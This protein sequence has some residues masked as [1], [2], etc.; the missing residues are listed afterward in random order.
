MLSAIVYRFVR[1]QTTQDYWSDFPVQA[2]IVKIGIRDP[3]IY[4]VW[5]DTGTIKSQGITL[6]TQ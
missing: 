1:I 3:T 6:T 4:K 5:S 2:P